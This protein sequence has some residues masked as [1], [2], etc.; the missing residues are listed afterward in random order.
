MLDFGAD[1]AALIQHMTVH[2]KPASDELT[3]LNKTLVTDNVEYRILA[4][5]AIVPYEPKFVVF[6]G[7]VTV[8]LSTHADR[9]GVDIS[10]TVC[11]YVCLFV[12]VWLRIF[13]QRRKLVTSNFVRRFICVPGTDSLIFLNF[14]PQEAQNRR[15]RAHYHLHD[16][17]NDYPL[18]ERTSA[19]C[20]RRIA[21]QA[22]P[23]GSTL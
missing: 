22:T 8:F 5:K 13:P 17:Y 15:N 1:S 21:R 12:F 16:V 10:F 3:R 20:G 4:N 19:V 9:Q 2:C 14:A 7:Q 23:K 18:H 11:L 6:S